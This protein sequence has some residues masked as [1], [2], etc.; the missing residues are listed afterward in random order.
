MSKPEQVHFPTLDTVRGIAAL[1]VLLHHLQLF[2][3]KSGFLS[4]FDSHIFSRLIS[5]MGANC[6]NLFFCLS[7]FLLTYLL[8]VEKGNSGSIV[9]RNFYVRR[10]LRI[11]PLFFLI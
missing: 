8:L 2:N 4:L 9:I 10:F 3:K 6:V 5:S 11:W 7:G 1:G